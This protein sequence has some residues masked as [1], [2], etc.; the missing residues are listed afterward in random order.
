ML[1]PPCVRTSGAKKLPHM[2]I[3]GQFRVL[4]I[5]GFPMDKSL[6][7]FSNHPSRYMGE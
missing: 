3:L 6:D 7:Q 2:A 1:R 5:S 4:K